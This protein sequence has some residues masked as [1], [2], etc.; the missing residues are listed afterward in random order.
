[1][2][3]E[4]QIAFRHVEPNEAA[5]TRILEEIDRLELLDD[6]LIACR[7]MIEL[8]ERRHRKGNRYHVRIDLVMPG[9]EFVVDRHPPKHSAD[10]D[11]LIAIGE[12]FDAARKRLIQAKDRRRREVKHHEGRPRG[13]ISRLVVEEDYGFIE[14]ADGHEVYFHRNAVASGEF[15]RLEIGRAVSFQEEQGEKGPQ[16]TIVEL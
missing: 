2:Q 11:L 8:P 12:A 6:R 14:A 15:D 13:R 5:R 4:P 3:T 16:A 9:E 7:L 10:E 1:M